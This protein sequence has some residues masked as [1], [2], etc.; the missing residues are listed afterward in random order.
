MPIANLHAEII[1]VEPVYIYENGLT[2]VESI[3]V[4]LADGMTLV[5]WDDDIDFPLY[6]SYLA[7][8]FW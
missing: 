8:T 5:F 6:L 7:Y 2:F 1:S 4:K 3:R